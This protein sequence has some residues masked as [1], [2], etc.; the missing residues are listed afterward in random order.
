MS[1]HL[2]SMPS[3]QGK[4]TRDQMTSPHRND[5][6]LHCLQHTDL[7]LLEKQSMMREIVCR[8][9]MFKFRFRRSL[10]FYLAPIYVTFSEMRLPWHYQIS[11]PGS[12]K[13]VLTP[14]NLVAVLFYI[15]CMDR[16]VVDLPVK[17]AV[18]LVFIVTL[19]SQET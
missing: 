17:G 3:H 9:R 10:L 12:Q 6:I 13:N 19:N 16:W 1:C 8:C 15:I 11:L 4:H 14:L 2:A 5:C 18:S 7:K